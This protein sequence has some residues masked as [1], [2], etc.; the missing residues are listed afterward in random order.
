MK[1]EGLE[2]S[3][4]KTH[5]SVGQAKEFFKL[6]ILHVCSRDVYSDRSDTTGST[7]EA[8]RAGMSVAMTAIA[9]SSTPT[10]V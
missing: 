6:F 3:A 4:G 9:P 1:V 5:G 2:D 10:A 8:R 7:R